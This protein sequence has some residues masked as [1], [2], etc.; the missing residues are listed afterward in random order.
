MDWERFCKDPNIWLMEEERN[1]AKRHVPGATR[2]RREANMLER[3]GKATLYRC[4]KN[5][6]LIF[7]YHY[8]ASARRDRLNQK[9]QE[10]ANR[11]R[12]LK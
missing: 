3:E 8:K 10:L 6:H 5:Q 7:K 4:N 1:P 11:S 9:K 12:M 2:N